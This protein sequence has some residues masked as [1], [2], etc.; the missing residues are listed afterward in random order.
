MAGAVE[1]RAADAVP[2]S[3]LGCGLLSNL[4]FPSGKANSSALTIHGLHFSGC[5]LRE[6]IC[7]FTVMYCEKTGV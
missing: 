3:G 2:L 4:T 7:T 5:L 6:T 1:M